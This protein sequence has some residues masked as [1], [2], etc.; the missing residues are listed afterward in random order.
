MYRFIVDVETD[1]LYGNLLTLAVL[2][3]DQSGHIIEEFYAG[4][5]AALADV[6][7]AWV[8][9]H[10]VAKAGNY[11]N[12]SSEQELLEIFWKLWLTYRGKGAICFV[13]VAVPVEAAIWRKV[14]LQNPSERA[15]L[16]PFPIIDLA[17][18]LFA[19]GYDPLVSRKQLVPEFSG[20]LHNALDD[21]RLT[22]AVLSEIL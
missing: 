8:R 17:S 5:S 11:Q 6:K 2:V 12:F 9:E 4:L 1:G 16:A 7:E 10:V 15:F 19:K 22:N 13:D 20:Q 18:L 21:V 14:I 3:S